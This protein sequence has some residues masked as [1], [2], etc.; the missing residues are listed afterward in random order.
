M[1]K[2]PEQNPLRV[3]AKRGWH[4]DQWCVLGVWHGQERV[5]FSTRNLFEACRWARREEARLN[6][7]STL[8]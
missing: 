5:L 7:R 3:F 1:T 4:G 8:A 2:S 6:E